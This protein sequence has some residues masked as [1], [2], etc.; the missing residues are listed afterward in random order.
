[1]RRWKTGVSHF[2]VVAATKSLKN[3]LESGAKRAESALVHAWSG[4]GRFHIK[5]SFGPL[6][7]T[8]K[9]CYL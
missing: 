9:F 1:M 2:G 4:K 5:K 7:T 8:T 6:T 3:E